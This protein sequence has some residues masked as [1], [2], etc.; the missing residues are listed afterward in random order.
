MPA[1]NS[2]R[3]YVK[4]A[5][6]HSHE[7]LKTWLV[8]VVVSLYRTA[9]H[10]QEFITH[11]H[12]H[13][14]AHLR[15][16]S[17]R[18]HCRRVLFQEPLL[19]NMLFARLSLLC[20]HDSEALTAQCTMVKLCVLASYLMPRWQVMA[21]SRV[22]KPLVTPYKDLWDVWRKRSETRPLFYSSCLHCEWRCISY[23]VCKIEK[24]S[25]SSRL[26]AALHNVNDPGQREKA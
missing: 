16:M 23:L 15:F 13:C 10:V 19:T 12:S 14:S 25:N 3:Q 9:R 1:L 8:H 17:W 26:V 18:Y 4:L 6:I 21:S 5:G 2:K 20:L 22:R 11:V 7:I 24:K